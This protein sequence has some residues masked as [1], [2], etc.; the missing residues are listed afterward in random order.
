MNDLSITA[1]ICTV[2]GAAMLFFGGMSLKVDMGRPESWRTVI[3]MCWM[4]IAAGI[5]AGGVS[6][7]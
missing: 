6:S 3:I 7:L 5:F 1:L 2:I 4:A